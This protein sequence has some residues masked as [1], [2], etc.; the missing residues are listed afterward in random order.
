MVE[1]PLPPSTYT[2]M[3]IFYPFINLILHFFFAI[4]ISLEASTDN[5][6]RVLGPMVIF[7]PMNNLTACV[8][9]F[10]YP[11]KV[12]GFRSFTDENDR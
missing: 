5:D 12:Y 6:I 1:V 3:L 11:G 2:H 9:V 4:A 10:F 7:F 8:C